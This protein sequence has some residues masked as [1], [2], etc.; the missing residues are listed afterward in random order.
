MK[1]DMLIFVTRTF[2]MLIVYYFLARDFLQAKIGRLVPSRILPWSVV[3]LDFLDSI[4]VFLRP[5][6]NHYT[7]RE[8]LYVNSRGYVVRAKST[9]D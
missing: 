2:H 4:G 7:S 3:L 9:P 8:F 5:I 6:Y 1:Q